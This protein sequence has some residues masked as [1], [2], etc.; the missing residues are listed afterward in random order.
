[1]AVYGK[2]SIIWSWLPCLRS[3]QSVLYPKPHYSSPYPHTSIY[4]K[5]QH[6]PSTCPQYCKW[7]F[8]FRFFRSVF[9]CLVPPC[10][11]ANRQIRLFSTHVDLYAYIRLY[12]YIYIYIYIYMC[13]CVCVCVC[14]YTHIQIRTK[15]SQ[16]KTQ[17]VLWIF[18]LFKVTRWQHVS[19]STVRPSSGHK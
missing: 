1:M 9:A 7:P 4:Y 19:A 2:P 17:L 5:L 18:I 15:N 6:Y 14:V 11:H 3:I 12:I 16:V 8:V 10:W 13:V